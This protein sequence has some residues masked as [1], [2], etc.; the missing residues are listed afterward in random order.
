MVEIETV[1]T[2]F[3]GCAINLIQFIDAGTSHRTDTVGARQKATGHL[4]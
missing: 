4:L 1:I 2:K 3:D